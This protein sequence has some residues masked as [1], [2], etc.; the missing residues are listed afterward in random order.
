MAGTILATPPCFAKRA[1]RRSL[2][3][4]VGKVIGRTLGYEVVHLAA[5][6]LGVLRPQLGGICDP[7][8]SKIEEDTGLCPPGY[9][10]PERN[11]HT[12]ENFNRPVPNHCIDYIFS[13]HSQENIDIKANLPVNSECPSMYI[14]DRDFDWDN[15]LV[16]QKATQQW[17][18]FDRDWREI[19][20]RY[21]RKILPK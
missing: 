21:L 17:H 18:Y 20:R 11:Y 8:A 12:H 3:M 2:A 1:R 10:F 7:L 6:G 14:S 15:A 19:E 13:P 4:A 16:E 5:Q 9:S